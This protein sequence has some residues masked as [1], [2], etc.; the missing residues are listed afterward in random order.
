[1]HSRDWQRIEDVFQGAIDLDPALRD[2]YLDSACQGDF[3]LRHCVTS[4]IVSAGLTGGFLADAV[5]QAAS[6]VVQDAGIPAG[7]RFGSYEIVRKLAQ[8]GMGAVYLALRA[9]ETY[10]LQAAIKV[11]RAGLHPQFLARFRAERRILASLNHPHIARL[12]DGGTGPGGQPYVVMEYV[13]GIPIDDYCREHNLAVRER[14]RLFLQVCDAVSYAHRNLI[15]HRDIKPANVLV[16]AEGTVKLLDFGISRLISPDAAGQGAALTQTNERLLTPDFAS[17][18]QILGQPLAVTTDVYSLGVLLYVLLS[19][20]H[21]H[22]RAR[23]SQFDL[24]QAICQTDPEKPSTAATRGKSVDLADRIAGDLDKITLQ[25]LQ[26]DPQRRYQTCEAF[27]EDIRRYLEG[28]PVLAVG[29][30]WQYRAGKFLRRNKLLAGGAAAIVLLAAG[31]VVSLRFE[32][33]RLRERFGQVRELAESFLFRFDESIRNV[34][35]TTAA[36]QLVVAEGLKYLSL[37]SAEA[38]GDASLREEL[39]DATGRIAEIQFGG[40]S[41]LGDLVGAEESLRR[42]QAI[43][44]PLLAARPRDEPLQ[45]KLAACYGRLAETLQKDSDRA[46]GAPEYEEKEARLLSA[47]AAAHPDDLNVLHDLSRLDLRRSFRLLQKGNPKEAI[48]P[49]RRAVEIRKHAAGL[50]SG[51][52]AT[53]LDYASALSQLGD[54]LGGGQLEFNLGDRQGALDAYRQAQS[55]LEQ[56]YRVAPE[57]VAA[58]SRLAGIHGYLAATM[59]QMGDKQGALAEAT[60][61]LALHKDL[62]E[63]DPANVQAARE[64]VLMYLDRSHYQ[65]ELGDFRA[66]EE[67]C[68]MALKL[69]ES[70][71]AKTPQNLEAQSDTASIANDLGELL[72]GAKRSADAIPPF[73]HALAMWENLHSHD[74]ANQLYLLYRSESL[75]GRGQ[76]EFDLQ[77]FEP[78]A[79]DLTRALAGLQELERNGKLPGSSKPE[80]A[81][82]EQQIA[83]CRSRRK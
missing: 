17:P 82:L 51:D 2:A 30:H 10:R 31:W 73:T 9:D 32:Q 52:A 24:Q 62:S 6:E 60:E 63:R 69:S 74:S 29:N 46:A 67:G 57:N 72:L 55:V 43:L 14:L 54:V 50:K 65:M 64:A 25:A 26:K 71:L 12:L 28:Y 79:A 66:A 16:T 23:K 37:L 75:Q 68:R 45:R 35:G 13:D 49:A 58:A 7:T 36:R 83:D 39:A 15:I 34:T 20:S 33:A 1:M 18:E 11:V 38:S 59:F 78:A 70:L 42:Q 77:Q 48:E 22:E 3:E 47:L 44:E 56:V 80:I 27:M 5:A 53:Q 76:A 40:P 8:G 21:P 41:H 19:E 61:S 4:L 81:K